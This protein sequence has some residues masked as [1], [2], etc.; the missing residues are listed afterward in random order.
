MGTLTFSDQ[1]AKWGCIK[2]FKGYFESK[3]ES[4]VPENIQMRGRRV[5]LY[6][7]KDFY[8]ANIQTDSCG[9]IEYKSYFSDYN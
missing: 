2:E 5:V 9:R 7:E 8:T 3:S 1:E 6:F 4:K